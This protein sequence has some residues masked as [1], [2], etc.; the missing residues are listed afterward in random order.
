MKIEIKKLSENATLPTQGS[1]YAAGYDLYAAEEGVVLS[2]CRLLIKTNI[3]VSIPEGYY[4][5]IAPRSGLAYKSGL[6]VMAGVIDADYRGDIGVILYNT[7]VKD[8]EFKKGDR[9]AQL[10]IEKCHNVE[11]QEVDELEDSVRSDGGFGSTG[12]SK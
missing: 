8:F 1:K 10:I 7:D 6:D 2:E 5:R 4:G 11:W 12:V 3:S 9:I